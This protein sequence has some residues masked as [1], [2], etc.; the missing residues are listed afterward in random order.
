MLAFGGTQ[1]NGARHPVWQA[2]SLA[3]EDLICE[4]LAEGCDAYW[5]NGNAAYRVR[6]TMWDLMPRFC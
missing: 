3:T 5:L 6:G 1:K 4:L 2:P